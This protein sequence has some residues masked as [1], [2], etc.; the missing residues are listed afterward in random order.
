MTTT[1][2]M[3]NN[4]LLAIS[5]LC[6][7][8]N[9][10]APSAEISARIEEAFEKDGGMAQEEPISF[11]PFSEIVS[12]SKEPFILMVV[13]TGD[14][15]KYSFYDAKERRLFWRKFAKPPYKDPLTNIE[16]TSVFEYKYN[17]AS[18]NKQFPFDFV[19]EVTHKD[20]LPSPFDIWADD[21]RKRTANFAV[22]QVLRN[23][24]TPTQE[25]M[26]QI[27]VI[28]D[29]PVDDGLINVLR[30]NAIEKATWFRARSLKAPG[31]HY[32]DQQLKRFLTQIGF[33]AD[34]T[35]K[36]LRAHYKNRAN[37]N[38][39]LSNA[40]DNCFLTQRD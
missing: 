1:L 33:P 28:L 21:I 6:F 22:E 31:R 20:L 2:L 37:E 14:P 39:T 25:D 3:R 40:G 23:F 30:L 8:I 32:T 24:Q 10:I 15:G 19:K 17:P 26:K 5:F 13:P 11:M 29:T 9:G 38:L 4:A 27:Y 16:I 34:D 35:E 12:K 36:L 18:T 7:R